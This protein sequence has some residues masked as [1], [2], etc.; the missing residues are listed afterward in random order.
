MILQR[1]ITLPIILVFALAVLAAY[2]YQVTTLLQADQQN[3]Q[4]ALRNAERLFAAESSAQQQQLYSLALQAAN[5]IEIQAALATAD[6]ARLL[7]LVQPKFTSLSTAI[8]LTKI[9]FYIRPSTLIAGLSTTNTLITDI[10][11]TRPDIMDVLANARTYQGYTFNKDG[12][13]LTVILPVRQA[14]RFVGALEYQRQ[15]G[16]D[17]LKILA[18][19]SGADLQI[20]AQRQVVT[21]F[22]TGPFASWLDTPYPDLVLLSS[23]L[24]VPVYGPLQ[25]YQLA[26]EGNI[27]NARTTQASQAYALRT[28]G[29]SDY[30]GNRLGV[31]QIV[32]DRSPQT[33]SLTNQFLLFS[34]TYFLVFAGGLLFIAYTTSHNL[35]PLPAL[36]ETA[37]QYV[38]AEQ[39]D[40][41]QTPG[42]PSTDELNQLQISIQRL[43]QQ[44]ASQ[45]SEL[46]QRVAERTRSLERR[47]LQLQTAAEVAR[48]VASAQNLDT[49]LNQAVELIRSR[50]NLYYTAVFL[51]DELNL[52][53]H[54]RAGTGSAGENM[55]AAGHKLKIGEVGLVGFVT[56][57]GQPRIALDVGADA[58]HFKNPHLPETRS[59]MAL[60]LKAAGRIIG[61]LDVQ[62]SQPSAFDQED[63]EILQTLADQL[64]VA[65]EN[66][67]LVEQTEQTLQQSRLSIRRQVQQSWSGAD[68][69]ASMPAFAYDRMQIIP[70]QTGDPLLADLSPDLQARLQ[71][72]QPVTLKRRGQNPVLLVPVMLREQSIGVIGVEQDETTS[73]AAGQPGS[74]GSGWSESQISMLQAIANQA[75]LTIENARLLAETKRQAQQQQRISTLATSVRQS[76]D[77]DSVLATTVQEIGLL[78]NI[79]EVEIR[80]MSPVSSGPVSPGPTRQY[81]DANTGGT[82]NQP[83]VPPIPSPENGSAAK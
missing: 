22:Q 72:G 5:D 56:A 63:I 55:L 25:V 81:P 45:V 1:R 10:R 3:Y 15:L 35:S 70:L 76:L 19:Q 42:A 49:L 14:G 69:A 64:A 17:E 40:P 52:Y 39:P 27:A 65:I 48:D 62:S 61:A 2:A 59:E 9:N 34:L 54:L 47:S 66:V 36:L 53:A 60:P 75:A 21:P 23:T 11:L 77:L 79:P 20:I 4:E 43:R 37:R 51:V 71:S 31:I 74:A 82:R 73:Q 46:E 78:M 38:Q 80:L 58:V 29:L 12:L 30:L 13:L 6:R 24:N 68:I 26:I 44:L 57:R 32:L 8:G 28:I 33:Q 67:R 16:G 50:F 18:S 83:P 7:D 41:D